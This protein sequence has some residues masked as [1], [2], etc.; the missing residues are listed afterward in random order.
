MPE[1]VFNLSDI[2]AAFEHG[3][4]FPAFQPIFELRTGQLAGFEV[5]ARWR[6]PRHGFIPPDQFIPVLESAGQ[7][8]RLTD[9]ILEKTF[10]VPA[11][12][13][14]A[15]RISVNLSSLQLLDSTLPERIGVAAERQQFAVDRLNFEITESAL[16][17]DLPRAMEVAKKLKGMHCHLALDDFGTGYSSLR[18]LHALPFDELK[19]DREFVRTMAE[20]RESRKIVASVVGLGQSL[21][22]LTVAEGVE[23]AD[24]ANMLRWMGADLAQGWLYGRPVSAEEVP[25]VIFRSPRLGPGAFSVPPND[26]GTGPEGPPAHRLAQLQ[27]IYDSAPVGLC[28]LDCSLRYISINRRLADLNGVPVEAHLGRTPADV[29]PALFPNVEPFIRSA[30]AGEPIL[31]VEFHNPN[32]EAHT[33]LGSYQPV[34]DAAGE[35]V[36]VSVAVMDVTE[37]KRIEEMLREVE[38]HY[39]NLVDLSPHVPWVLNMRGELIEAGARWQ[40]ITG[41]PIREALGEGWM[42][43]LHPQDVGPT[44]DAIRLALATGIPLDLTYRVR[45][46]DGQWRWMRSRGTPRLTPSGEMI[47]FYGVLEEMATHP[48]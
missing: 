15:L 40:S 10:S 38:E 18:H 22:L 9:L 25:D 4:F 23:G 26:L 42:E 33:L 6:H 47:G 35:V 34:R 20:R 30:L 16:L 32:N 31:G 21:G 11:L 19:I 44:R 29:I 14:S 13:Q 24:Q 17:D 5:L 37:R 43:V 41:Q 27:A 3:E 8:D 7:I 12:R 45:E 39:R 1:M 48:S 36:G 28:L 2:A 46:R